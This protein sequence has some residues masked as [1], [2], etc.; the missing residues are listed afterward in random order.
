MLNLRHVERLVAATGE[1]P[2][3][4]SIAWVLE[5]H[6][7]VITDKDRFCAE[8]VPL[9]FGQAK[10]SSF[11]RKLY[12]WGFR[13]VNLAP[14]HFTESAPPEAEFF[15]NE[16]FQRDK[17]E[18]LINM[19]SVTAAKTRTEQS[20][21]RKKRA[22]SRPGVV[23]GNIQPNTGYDAAV[24]G[25]QIFPAN[26][27]APQPLPTQA[28][29]A[30]PAVNPINPAALL[31][32]LSMVNLQSQL[33]A[34]HAGA[35]VSAPLDP[36]QLLL[37]VFNFAALSQTQ[38]D[39][40]MS[41]PP[42]LPQ[43]P[44]V[45]PQATRQNAQVIQ[46]APAAPPAQPQLSFP[47]NFVQPLAVAPPAPVQV[48]PAPAQL[49]PGIAPPGIIPLDPSGQERLLQVIQILLL[50]QNGQQPAPAPQ[51]QPPTADP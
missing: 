47:L 19:K 43:V 36:T 31:Q 32:A 16:F 50:A 2:L 17:I 44:L 46:P 39:P 23:P 7:F 12:R 42:I 34:T 4:Q 1:D 37:S 51:D 13:K 45:L 20:L 40:N 48:Q 33:N 6:A 11:T 29:F 9:F 25:Q 30:Q 21:E 41:P 35:P 27:F 22:M 49:Q 3:E 18:L 10:F 8:W 24:A 26:P 14:H 15:G 5:G 38:Q 28:G